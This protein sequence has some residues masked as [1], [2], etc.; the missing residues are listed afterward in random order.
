G[1]GLVNLNLSALKTLRFRERFSLQ[2]RG[3]AF[4][5]VNR[6]NYGEPGKSF[7]SAN[8]GVIATA[9][10]ARILQFGLTLKF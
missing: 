10:D 3:E 8:F 9:K 6:A 5:F 7:G 4:N 1:P 2:F